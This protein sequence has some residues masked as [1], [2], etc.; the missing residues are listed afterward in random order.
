MALVGNEPSVTQPLS[1]ARPY[2]LEREEQSY[3]RMNPQSSTYD[4]EHLN[5][6]LAIGLDLGWD[7]IDH[8]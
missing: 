6:A 1:N 4:L 3:S 7:N 8:L 5:Q 2:V